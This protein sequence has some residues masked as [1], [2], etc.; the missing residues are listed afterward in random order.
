MTKENDSANY[1]PLIK[2]SFIMNKRIKTLRIAL[3]Q[4]TK[5]SERLE[6][7]VDWETGTHNMD[8]N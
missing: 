7:I 5:I 8:E 3:A 6:D 4:I 1:S 2:E